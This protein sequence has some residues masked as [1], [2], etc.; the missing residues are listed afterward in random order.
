MKQQFNQTD[1]PIQESMIIKKGKEA[2]KNLSKEQKKFNMLTQKI[3][4]LSQEI[5]D[6]EIALNLALTMYHE[7]IMPLEKEIA[8]S[9]VNLAVTL[10]YMLQK[11][12]YTNREQL[13]MGLLIEDL[14]DEA[15]SEI[16]PNDEQKR[17]YNLYSNSGS[18]EEQEEEGFET[19]VNDFIN[20]VWD[21]FKV[22]LTPDELPDLRT[23]TPEDLAIFMRK[24]QELA[25]ERQD[26]EEFDENHAQQPKNKRKKTAKQIE[27]EEKQE[28]KKLE[29]EARKKVEEEAKNKTVRSLYLSLAKVLHPDS[30]GTEEEQELKSELMKQVTGAYKE[31][32]LLT[33]LKLEMQWINSEEK[34]VNSS[35]EKLKLYNQMLSD[36]AIELKQEMIQRF[37]H[38]RYIDVQRYIY[39]DAKK[40]S[41]RM[42][43]EELDLK[44]QLKDIQV[45]LKNLVNK[46]TSLQ[47]LEINGPKQFN[48][49]KFEGGDFMGFFD[50][51]D[52]FDD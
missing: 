34:A 6:K 35:D 26:Q 23:A 3:K 1:Q 27:R 16:E 33:L 10:H 29:Q 20:M 43:D 51:F 44:K 18:Y 41:L 13:E 31:N 25:A 12:K 4:N 9:L 30:G 48:P 21:Q 5:A 22:R 40:I 42:E 15:F 52:E 7:V 8:E 47:F 28:A 32:D 50:E 49:Y 37:M 2:T 38:M 39:M 24:I 45:N 17:I 14:F 36:Q 19:T 46:K 11:Y